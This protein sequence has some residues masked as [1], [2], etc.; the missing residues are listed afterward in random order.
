MKTVVFDY[1]QRNISG[2][3][4]DNENT[5]I[6]PEFLFSYFENGIPEKSLIDWV[7][8]ELTN[9]DKIFLDI[10]AHVGTWAISLAKFFR[11][12]YAFEPQKAVYNCLCGSIALSELSHLITPE[13][14]AIANSPFE[15]ITIHRKTEGGGETSI[16]PFSNHSFNEVVKTKKLNTFRFPD[17]SVGLIKI[18]VEGAELAV[19]K[20]GE[21]FLKF[22]NYPP[23]LFECWTDE[24]G[25]DRQ[26]VLDKITELGYTITVINGYPEMLLALRK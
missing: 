24:R 5:F 13:E 19:I 3:S 14:V 8:Q 7:K 23:I 16:I 4:K 6:V 17:N 21:V 11:H 9:K 2:L 12:T 26:A 15:H 10:G 25:Q 20:G 22:N 18:D 1:K